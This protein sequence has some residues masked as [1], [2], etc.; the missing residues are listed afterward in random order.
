L[1]EPAQFLVLLGVAGNYKKT[2]MMPNLNLLGHRETGIYGRTS[3]AE[4][5]SQVCQR[6][7]ELRV[8]I[9]FR[10][11]NSEGDLVTWIQEAAGVFQVIVLNAA[12]YMHTSVALRDAVASVAVPTIEIHLSNV[13]GREEFRRR[14]MIAGVCAGQISGFGAGS[15]LLGLEAAVNLNEPE[16]SREMAAKR[17]Q[18]G[19]P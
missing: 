19:A 5:E 16:I 10:Q 4:I 7:F 2:A 12:A 13:H 9:E 6:A 3:L 11:T 8:E 1:S 15:Y 18:A 17:S 14:S